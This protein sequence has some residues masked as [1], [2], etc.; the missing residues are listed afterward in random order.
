MINYNFEILFHFCPFNITISVR[1][2]CFLFEYKKLRERKRPPFGGQKRR[3]KHYM[4][5]SI[6]AGTLRLRPS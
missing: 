2:Q 4:N 3:K 1:Y 5:I 6:Q